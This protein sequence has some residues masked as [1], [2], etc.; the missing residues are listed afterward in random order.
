V[1]GEQTGIRTDTLA[2]LTWSLRNGGLPDWATGVG[3]ATLI[4][5]D[6]AG[7]ADTL[8]L[9]TAVWFAVD[10]GASVR[11]IGDDQQLAAIGAGGVLR[12]IQQTHGAL[13]LT[14][15]HRFTDPAE[16]QASLALREGD[17]SALG[18]L[19]RL[20]PRSCR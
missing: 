5:I 4:I 3:P 1:L 9:D 19:S 17:P 18:F 2:K 14:E 10:H 6:E 13:Q 11:L 20:W 15:L 16:A 8:S 12:D 7:M